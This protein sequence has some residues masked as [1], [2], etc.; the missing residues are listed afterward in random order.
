VAWNAS[1]RRCA[2]PAGKL[3]LDN[4]ARD[5][6][7]ARRN[8]GKGRRFS[9]IAI[10]ALALGI[11]ASSIVLSVAYNVFFHAPPYKDFNRSVVFEIRNTANARGSQGRAYFSTGEFHAFLE[12]NHIFEAMI[13]MELRDA[14]SSMTPANPSAFY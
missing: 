6:R 3:I 2:T 11:G 12:Q 1:R 14:A 9:L 13:P 10:L 4:L 7:Y 8:L 5:L